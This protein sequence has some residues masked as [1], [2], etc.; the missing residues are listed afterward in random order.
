MCNYSDPFGLCPKEKSK[1]ECE[2]EAEDAVKRLENH[3][4]PVCKQLGG[5]ARRIKNAGN[6]DISRERRTRFFGTQEMTGEYH[7]GGRFLFWR[8]EA[9][10]TLYPAAFENG[11]LLKTVAHE[12][13]HDVDPASRNWKHDIAGGGG[14]GYFW[15]DECSKE[16]QES[17]STEE[18]AAP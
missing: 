5:A 8:Y 14:P 4:H 16:E 15:G 7:P 3:K 6:L 9:G 13:V 17:A 2:K 11:Q 12:A 10:M 18:G 1:E